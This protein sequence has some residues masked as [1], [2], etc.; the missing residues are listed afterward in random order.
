M[1]S[2][3]K[4]V[5]GVVLKIIPVIICLFFVFLY[6]S[7]G[8]EISV[9]NIVDF[10]KT[11]SYFLA[12]VILLLMFAIKSMTFFFPIMILYIV[13]GCI[14]PPVIA[15]IVS[16]IGTSAA[17]SV[18]YFIGRFSG[19]GIVE[20]I[21]NKY[22]K[23]ATIMSKQKSNEF[24]ISFLMRIIRCLPADV[25]SVYLGSLKFS[26]LP[27][28]IGGII[29]E[30][31]GL[32][33]ETLIGSSIDDTNSPLFIISIIMTVLISVLSVIFYVLYMRHNKK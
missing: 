13:S 11:D 12:A 29:G 18:P 21:E 5:M 28:V 25:V 10:I 1:L 22:P 19:A 16:I 27:Y 7:S 26:F 8:R 30:L 6:F 31:P 14:F 24:F 23:V 3:I 4:N 17:F 15:I 20:K 32:I 2:K 9:E 33:F